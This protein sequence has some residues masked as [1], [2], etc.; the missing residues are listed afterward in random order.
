MFAAAAWCTR[1][2]QPLQGRPARLLGYLW[3]A[4]LAASLV[5]A[6]QDAQQRAL[7]V[8]E[9]AYACDPFGYLIMAREVR[10]AVSRL[11]PPRFHLESAQTRSLIELMQSRQVPLRLWEEMVAPHAHHYFPHAGRVGV[12][13]PPGAALMLALFPE[14]R[15]VDG[16]NR[17]TIALLLVT[18]LLLLIVAGTRQA[19]VAAGFVT[20][21]LYL[22]LVILRKIGTDSYSVNATLAPLLLGF[23]CTFAAL[24]LR[25]S[26]EGH[27]AAWV[28]A[29]VGGC[30]VGFTIL[31]RLPMILLLPG[32]LI[33]LWPRSWL[34]S[35]RDSVVPF[36]LGVI[37][38]GILPLLAHQY[39][40]TGVWYLPT[41]GA[42]DNAPPSLDPLGSNVLYYLVGGRGST[43]NWA[44]FALL[45]GVAGGL[46]YQPRPPETRSHLG[47]RRL[48]VSAL[49][50]W[51][52]PTVYFLTHRV[53]TS[54]YTIPVTFA[55][56]LLLALG[57]LTIESRGPVAAWHGRPAQR[58]GLRRLALALA[59]L[60]GLVALIPPWLA[61]ARGVAPVERPLRHVALPTEL[62]AEQAWVWA[63][64]LSGTFWYYG[65]KP[66][67]KIGFSV[68]E[69]RAMAFRFVFER[70]DP[71]YLV[72]DSATMQDIMQEISRLGGTLEPRGEV[73]GYPYFLIHWPRGGP[74][75]APMHDAAS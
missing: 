6:A 2:R 59:L 46:A 48:L 31:I 9:Y 50:L 8:E 34:P 17:A 25:S 20:M 70:E 40:M 57:A 62:T 35:M 72:R 75:G 54:Y 36:A 42:A 69:V 44:I 32:L 66:A 27:R 30:W 65:N 15:A 61:Y 64:L 71:Q 29:L 68:P 56:V 55:T 14:G 51:A 18:G 24:G 22:G 43:Y 26:S 28:A 3:L 74:A 60:P 33:L 53:V 39:H 19:W 45:I 37:L 21:A 23:L 10:Q 5:V 41:Y 16:L 63:D 47:W 13:Y 4:G 58:G 38:T 12:Q 73:D 7:R 67:F 1:W 11:E 52:V 49:A